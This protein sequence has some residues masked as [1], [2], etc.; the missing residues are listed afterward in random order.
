M[1][2]KEVET[3]ET[4]K[5]DIDAAVSAGLKYIHTFIA[6]SDI[7]LNYKLKLTREQALAKAVDAVKYA[8]SLG[9]QVEFSAED[10]TRTDRDFLKKVFKSVADAGADVVDT[11]DG[12]SNFGCLDEAKYFSGFGSRSSAITEIYLSF[13]SLYLFCSCNNCASK[14]VLIC[15][16]SFISLFASA[17]FIVNSIFSPSII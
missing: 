10:A 12:N 1:N 17:I 3:Q 14:F 5:K 6:T 11:D 8:K 7:H 9:L 16:Y 4:E 13:S 2:E 15:L